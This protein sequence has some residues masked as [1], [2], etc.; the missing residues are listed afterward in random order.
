MADSELAASPYLLFSSVS[1]PW[2]KWCDVQYWYS[3]DS[4]S[5][6]LVE[7]LDHLPLSQLLRDAVLVRRSYDVVRL[8]AWRRRVSRENVVRRDVDQD[9]GVG[10]REGGES[11]G[12]GDVQLHQHG[13]SMASEVRS[14]RVYLASR[15]RVLETV[16]GSVRS[17]VEREE[18]YGLCNIRS[19]F[20]SA[21]YH[22]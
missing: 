12:E 2:L 11:L 21:V 3:K 20:C 5:T 1:V 18:T 22:D 14:E 10:D 4:P 7:S 15:S 6:S 9:E 16:R 17:R 13:Q 8:V 19:S